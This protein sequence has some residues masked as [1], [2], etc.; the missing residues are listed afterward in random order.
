M[1]RTAPPK[2]KA[3]S[4]RVAAADDDDEDGTTARWDPDETLTSATIS[5]CK[6][7]LRQQRTLLYA[8]QYLKP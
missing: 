5:L 4:I 6:T 8:E 2:V 7:P 1:L 3:L